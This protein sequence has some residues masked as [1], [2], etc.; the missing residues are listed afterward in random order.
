MK[1]LIEAIRLEALYQSFRYEG[2][3]Y[4][5]VTNRTKWLNVRLMWENT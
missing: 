2:Y 4:M 5:V 3:N 1:E